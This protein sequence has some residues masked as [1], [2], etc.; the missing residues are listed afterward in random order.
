MGSRKRVLT[1]LIIFMIV[2]LIGVAGFKILGGRAWSVLDSV[3]MTAITIGTIGYSE[4]HDLSANP[5]ARTFTAI[6][7]FLCLGTIAFAVSSITAFVVE[8]E[9]IGRAHV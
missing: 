1:A 3:Y 4:T 8:G 7:I 5:A 2:F 6:Y 9:Q